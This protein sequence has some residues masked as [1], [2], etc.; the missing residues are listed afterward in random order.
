MEYNKTNFSCWYHLLS[1]NKIG[2][3]PIVRDKRDA[4]SQ[5]ANETHGDSINL[6]NIFSDNWK[7][8]AQKNETFVISR[9]LRKTISNADYVYINWNWLKIYLPLH[10]ISSVWF[11][12]LIG[13]T[14]T[15]TLHE[16]FFNPTKKI[17]HETYF[18]DN[19]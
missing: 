7:S 9:S 2:P 16:L 4:R 15:H 17:L 3:R 19:K 8:T 18:S 13:Q 10:N 1:C 12:D 6:S 14:Q 5:K 11:P